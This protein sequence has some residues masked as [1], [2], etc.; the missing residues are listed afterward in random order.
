MCRCRAGGPRRAVGPRRVELSV[1]S[2]LHWGALE[3][4]PFPAHAWPWRPS[5]SPFPGLRGPQ[6]ARAIA[7]P[8]PTR[9]GVGVHGDPGGPAVVTPRGKQIPSLP[10]FLPCALGLSGIVLAT[11][12]G[13]ATGPPPQLCNQAKEL[14]P[15]LGCLVCK[16]KRRKLF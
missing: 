4:G 8:S 3:Q 12:S 10:P 13:E 1:L 11:S 15:G 7:H 9:S 14:G 2:S 16:V 5:S 6:L